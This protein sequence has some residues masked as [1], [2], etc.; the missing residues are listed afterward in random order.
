MSGII[1]NCGFI[2]FY[3]PFEPRLWILYEITEFLLTS[4]GSLELI[5]DIAQ[6][7]QQVDELVEQGVQPTLAKFNYRC[8]YDGDRQYL[9]AWLELLVLLRRLCFTLTLFAK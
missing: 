5:P 7:L 6:Y 9:T 4:T 3:P 1:R 8:S 2:F